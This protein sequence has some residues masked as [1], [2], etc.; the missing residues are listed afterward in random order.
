MDDDALAAMTHKELI[1][2]AKELDV[3]V[4]I[5]V[6]KDTKANHK[7]LVNLILDDAEEE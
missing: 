5:A 4:P 1:G 3:K 6:K 7:K 2:L